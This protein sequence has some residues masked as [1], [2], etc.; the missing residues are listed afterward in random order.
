MAVT[1]EKPPT[2][3]P[4]RSRSV[5]S[6]RWAWIA[7]A[8]TPVAAVTG[9]V[10]QAAIANV[11]NVELGPM[12]SGNP[13]KVWQWVLLEVAA[14]SVALTAPVTALVF[15]VRAARSG[16]RSGTVAAIVAIAIALFFIWWLTV[17]ATTTNWLPWNQ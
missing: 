17:D 14:G 11:I 16:N 3:A 2:A 7:I 9:F 5:R 4:T 8:L 15:G 1:T 6:A 13:I 10:I 12:E